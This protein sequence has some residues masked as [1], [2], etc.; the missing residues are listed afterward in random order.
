MT[1]RFFDNRCQ[2]A[3]AVAEII[4]QLAIG[5]CFF[6]RIQILPLDILDQS[7]FEGFLVGKLANDRFDLVQLCPL[8]SAPATFAGN[9]LITR[10]MDYP[11]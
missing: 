3:L 6:D 2:F 7:N 11:R 8:G 9:D 5:L 4:A 1:P 10:A